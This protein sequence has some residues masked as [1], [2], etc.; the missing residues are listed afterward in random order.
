MQTKARGIYVYFLPNL[1]TSANLGAGFFSIIASLNGQLERAVYAIFIAA[2]FDSLDGRVARLAKAESAFGEE[3]DSLS[4][5]VSFGLAPAVLSYEWALRYMGRVGFVVAFLFV[6][7]GALRLARFNV[8]THVIPKSYFQGLP[9][10]MAAIILSSAWLFMGEVG[11]LP[12]HDASM[13]LFTM[14]DFPVLG[15]TLF[16]GILMIS[17]LR[18]PSF[19]ELHLESRH[20]MGVFLVSVGLILLIALRHEIMLFSF[21]M[22]YVVV[23]IAMNIRRHIRKRKRKSFSSLFYDEDSLLGLDDEGE[24]S[25]PST[26]FS[27]RSSSETSE[28][29]VK[30][31]VYSSSQNESDSDESE[32]KTS[33]V[34]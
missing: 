1:F 8:M 22:G 24:G 6:L 5:L 18:F 30:T 10:P 14:Q 19:K 29:L 11:F 7:C 20:L 4:D 33:K 12:N 25:P 31:E 9:I 27:S 26:G 32:P 3:Y 21:L 28:S 17:T 16:L 15:L 13:T 23:S 2:I 34:Y